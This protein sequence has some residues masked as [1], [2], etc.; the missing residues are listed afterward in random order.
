M[1]PQIV[2]IMTV[3]VTNIES[4]VIVNDAKKQLLEDVQGVPKDVE[5]IAKRNT[6]E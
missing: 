6:G 4:F 1:N 5:A 2:V 3:L